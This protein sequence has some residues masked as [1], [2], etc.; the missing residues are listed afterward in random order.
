MNVL[1]HI[2]EEHAD[3]RKKLTKIENAKGEQKKVIFKELF[4][5]IH[6]HHE[7]EEQVVFPLVKAKKDEK[8]QD[9]VLEMIEE[10][11]LGMHQFKVLDKT[12]VEDETWDA[13]FAVLK[14][15]L[16][17]HMDEEEKEFI[18][19]AQKA[20]TEKVLVD[21]LP[22]FESVLEDNLNKMMKKLDK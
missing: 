22:K 7:A 12:P 3:F 11:T 14:E 8:A 17:H 5:E 6:G 19:K 21:I 13:K 15:V 9:I 10:H 20:I 1:E 2:K 4:A 16:T 18:P